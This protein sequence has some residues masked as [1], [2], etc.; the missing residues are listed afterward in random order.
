M[1]IDSDDVPGLLERRGLFYTAGQGNH[2]GFYR[3]LAAAAVGGDGDGGHVDD[4]INGDGGRQF[5]FERRSMATNTED[6]EWCR[7]S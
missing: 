3:I 7:D 4:T 6:D 1:L 2:M 5:V